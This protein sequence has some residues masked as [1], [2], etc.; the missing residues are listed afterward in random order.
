MP[1]LTRHWLRQIV[2]MAALSAGVLRPLLLHG[3]EGMNE[4]FPATGP[5]A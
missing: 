4:I 2:S 5:E 3:A 1:Q